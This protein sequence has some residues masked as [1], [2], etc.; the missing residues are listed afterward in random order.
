[1]SEQKL[2]SMESDVLGGFYQSEVIVMAASHAAAVD[3]ACTAFDQHIDQN[4]KMMWTCSFCGVY[5]DPDEDS[6]AEDREAVTSSF[7]AE[8]M[9]K[10]EHIPSGRIL[11]SKS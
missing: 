7:R 1:M 6:Y 11:R 9:A 10:L 8:A 5:L 3:A 2:W 4:L